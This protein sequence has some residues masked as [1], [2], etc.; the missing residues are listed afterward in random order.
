MSNVTQESSKISLL[1]SQ[2]QKELYNAIVNEINQ[3]KKERPLVTDFQLII[4]FLIRKNILTPRSF[5]ELDDEELTTKQVG[6]LCNE[7][8]GDNF[9]HDPNT[10]RIWARKYGLGGKIG[11]R[12]VHSKKKWEQFLD[13]KL[14]TK[15]KGW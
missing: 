7:L 12:F 8:L 14:L 11:G 2:K 3:Q 9:K 1:L 13:A 10:A 6:K 15:V 4:E 5:F